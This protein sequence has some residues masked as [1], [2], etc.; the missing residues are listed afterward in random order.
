MSKSNYDVMTQQAQAL[1]LQYDQEAMLRKF[2]LDHD[3]KAIF[4]PFFGSAYRL[5][6]RSGAVTLHGQPAVHQ[7]AMSIY[8]MLCF[9]QDTPLL[10]G[11]WKSLGA[12]SRISTWNQQ[13]G[14]LLTQTAASFSGRTAELQSACDAMG[15]RKG[16]AGNVSAVFPA[17]PFFPVCLQFWDGDEEFP[18]ALQ[19]LWDDNA[20]AFVHYETLWYMTNFLCKELRDR[21]EL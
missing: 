7:A 19:I 2:P 5:D 20:L 3:E 15:G 11:S 12:L 4:V 13:S 14:T 9:S 21:M 17:F 6:R 10:R 16:P 18:P 8:D 1:F